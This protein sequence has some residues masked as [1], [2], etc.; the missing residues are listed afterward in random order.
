[1]SGIWGLV[2]GILIPSVLALVGVIFRDSLREY[3]TS[4][5]KHS[6]EAEIEKLK[7]DLA[8]KENEINALRDG[9]LSGM[10]NRRA[11]LNAR[12]L[13][14]IDRLWENV[15]ALGRLKAASQQISILN[16]D[17][18]NRRIETDQ[19]LQHF[20]KISSDS[21]DMEKVNISEAENQRPFVSL[22]SWA[23]FSAYNIIIASAVGTLK[24]LATGTDTTKIFLEEK[25]SDVLK[26]ALPHRS[27][28]IDNSGLAGRHYLL[29][30]LEEA[31]LVELAEMLDGKEDD[32]QAVAN[33]QDILEVVRKAKSK[34][35]SEKPPI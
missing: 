22:R 9:A 30:E 23:L 27:T 32:K 35:D 19:K 28:Y 24:M 21:F 4:G 25:I 31:L 15:V 3:I 1:M 7:A 8:H 13:Q 29:D 2:A 26:A 20:F 34:L 10:S 14:A 6:F 5:I 33:A 16:M 18:V 11:L 17:N 12:K